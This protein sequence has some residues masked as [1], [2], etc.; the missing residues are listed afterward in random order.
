M[1]HTIGLSDAT[2][3]PCRTKNLA[4][5]CENPWLYQ[6][7]GGHYVPQSKEFLELYGC[8]AGFLRQA[9]GVSVDNPEEW[10]EIDPILNN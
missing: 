3:S 7:R 6:Y 5:C 4:R 2:I 9:M 10:I 8:R 1:F